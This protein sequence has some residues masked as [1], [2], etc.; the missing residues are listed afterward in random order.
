MDRLPTGLK[1]TGLKETALEEILLDA[2]HTVTPALQLVVL[3]QGKKVID[4]SRG[5]LD[6]ETKQRPV[7]RDTRFDLASVSKLF[8]AAAL[9]RYCDAGII[10][11]HQPVAT[12][13]PE[14]SGLRSIQ[15]YENPLQSDDFVTVSDAEGEIDAG[16]ITFYHLLTHQSGLP[17]WRPLFRQHNANAARQMALTTFFSYPTTT[18]IV[19]SDI[20]LIL[21]GMALERIGSQSLDKV[22]HSQVLKPLRLRQTRYYPLPQQKSPRNVA[23]TE[24]CSWRKHRVI[25]EVH[26]ENAAQLGGVAGH[27]GLF[28]TAGDVARFGQSFLA[29]DGVLLRPQ[30]IAEMSR[31]HVQFGNLQSGEVRRGI[32]FALWSPDPE[33]SSNPLSPQT[34]GHTGFTGT[35]LWIDPT[36]QLVVALLTNDVY[37]G[38]TGRGIGPLRVKINRAIVDWVDICM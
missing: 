22:I 34:Y 16:K 24:F 37:H 30:T 29:G 38:R 9:M 25:G 21:T 26:D 27:A 12:I 17:A 7:R 4:L 6:P 31:L 14:F 19:Y 28:S 33:A 13:L 36:R 3:H 35:S 15:P 11:L 10:D 20:G 5:W 23:P 8:V 18:R 32:G 1:E 2:I